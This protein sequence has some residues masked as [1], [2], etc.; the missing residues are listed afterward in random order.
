MTR[1]L[2]VAMV[3]LSAVLLAGCFDYQEYVVLKKDGSGTLDMRFGMQKS[4]I[5]S[6]QAMSQAFNQGDEP[7]EEEPF[8]SKENIE[9]FLK[10][11]DTGVKLLS[12]EEAEEEGM[13]V[14]KI[15]YAFDNLNSIKYITESLND[16]FDAM[17]DMGGGTA[18]T[19]NESETPEQPE[20]SFVKQ[21]DGTWLFERG[22]DT[23]DNLSGMGG[24]MEGM[25]TDD[26]AAPEEDA[27][28]HEE[29]G[30]ADSQSSSE[31]DADKMM[32]GMAAAMGNSGIKLTVEFP[33][34]VI[35]SNATSVDGNKA[36]WE[37]K[38]SQMGKFPQKLRAI[39]K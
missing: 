9:A 35:E 3:V 27:E 11:H 37:Y 19:A 15:K 33:G 13:Q 14:W 2:L 8:I 12:Y 38:L 25:E 31:V 17:E 20:L 34:K 6:M 4:M 23:G 1:K 16:D 26:E 21:S 29:G 22:M 10:K 30:E 28:A 5:E 7:V 24:S 32:E 39:V 18:D 36:T